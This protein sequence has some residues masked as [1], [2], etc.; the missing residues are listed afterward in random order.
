MYVCTRVRVHVCT[1][2]HVS[3]EVGRPLRRLVAVP[4]NVTVTSIPSTHL[5][6]G[7]FF[8]GG[9]MSGPQG[10]QPAVCFV[11]QGDSEAGPGVQVPVP[12]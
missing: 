3:S 7:Q 2:V 4:A 10:P 8:T 12:R 6:Y 11:Q 1:Y 9:R 5:N